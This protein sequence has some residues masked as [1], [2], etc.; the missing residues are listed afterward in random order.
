MLFNVKNTIGRRGIITENSFSFSGSYLFASDEDGH[1]ELALLES[2]TLN[3]LQT[4]PEVDIFLVGCGQD[5][6]APDYGVYWDT[7]GK[8]GDGGRCKLESGVSLGDSCTAVV[9]TSGAE[10]TLTSDGTTYSSANGTM[11]KAGGQSAILGANQTSQLNS[12]GK[13]GVWLFGEEED[14]SMIPQLQGHRVGCSGGGGHCLS[15]GN[16]DS[17]VK[18]GQNAGGSTDGGAGGDSS[19][20]AG[21]DATG[22]GNGGGGAFAY[23]PGEYGYAGGAGSSGMIVVRDHRG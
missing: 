15:R 12:A 6:G 21:H 5:G 11:P 9:G 22:N 3:W 1:F 20:R 13:E 17:A 19:H 8:G 7:S 2:G 16:V 10:S 14:T 23:G 4:P 18:G